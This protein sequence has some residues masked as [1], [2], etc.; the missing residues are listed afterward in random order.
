M[1]ILPTPATI[2]KIRQF[3]EMPKENLNAIKANDV[4]FRQRQ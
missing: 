3:T 2:S 4:K 1:L